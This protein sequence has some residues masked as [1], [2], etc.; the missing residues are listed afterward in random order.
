MRRNL[1]HWIKSYMQ[2]TEN[3][4]PARQFQ[5]WTAF[6]VI[7]SVLR[8]KTW[9]SL[10][11]IKVHPNLYI[12][13][14]A[15]PGIA[16]KS[17]AITFGMDFLNQ[18]PEVQFSADAITREALLDDLEKSATED[19]LPDG[20][21]LRHS[22]LS[23]VAKEFESFLGQKK[24]NTKMLVL[25]TDLYD[26]PIDAWKYRTKH[27]GSNSIAAAYLNMQAATTP[28]SLASC[29]PATAIGGGLTSRIM[30]IWA[31]RKYKKVSR[32]IITPDEA[33]LRK[34]LIKDLYAISRITGEFVMTPE[35]E[36]K[37]DDWY[38]EY[39]EMSVQR[40]CQ[41]PAFDS[42]YSRKPGLVIKLS[43]ICSAAKRDET[44][45]EWDDILESMSY[46]E[47]AERNMGSSFRSVGRSNIATEIDMVLQIIKT[48]KVITEKEIMS[49][50]WK[51]MD[52]LKFDNVIETAIRTGR[53]KR[54]YNG[55]KGETGEI[56]YYFVG[57][58]SETDK[59]NPK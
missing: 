15:N 1:P 37:W 29:L 44:I 57:G 33:E 24:E 31:D 13:F 8:R 30:F 19:P 40:L 42:W 48:R 47:A 56:Y 32:P 18:I 35:A 9:L 23:I 11:R 3:T 22:S 14:V 28:D 34:L 6:S 2:F 45:V 12:V 5:L 59:T 49:I 41:D 54:K 27:S 10:G 52:S 58:K 43:I 21:T 51:D 50:V 55:P 25:L 7:A 38:L 39:E 4:E 17:Q 46:I 20:T 26:C 53:V 16:R 36:K